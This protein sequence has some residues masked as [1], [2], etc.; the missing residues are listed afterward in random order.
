M[1]A[2][3]EAG[4]YYQ[5]ELI[6]PV[7]YERDVMRADRLKSKRAGRICTERICLPLAYP[8]MR[9]LAARAQEPTP[10]PTKIALLST[11]TGLG[12]FKLGAPVMVSRQDVELP[13]ARVRSHSVPEA[14]DAA[15]NSYRC[16]KLLNLRRASLDL[17]L[18][19]PRPPRYP[20]REGWAQP[21]L[22]Q[23][24]LSAACKKLQ[25]GEVLANAPGTCATV[26]LARQA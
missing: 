6:R 13:I 26:L 8:L 17:R 19:R 10:A 7:P 14:P 18:H 2:R 1:S 16:L 4:L 23:S 12:E 24:A 20:L 5:S 21:K 11:K 15:K 22:G 9:P 3:L 25:S